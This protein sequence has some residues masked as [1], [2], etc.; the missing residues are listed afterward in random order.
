MVT[1]SAFSQT[2]GELVCGMA[3]LG[4]ETANILTWNWERDSI[5]PNAVERDRGSELRNYYYPIVESH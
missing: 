2:N 4:P 3:G 5:C 1:P